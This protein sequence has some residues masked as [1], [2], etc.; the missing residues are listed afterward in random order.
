MEEGGSTHVGRKEGAPQ[1]RRADV[2]CRV[3]NP[4]HRHGGVT[5][6]LSRKEPF[7]GAQGLA[8]LA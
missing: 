2:S 7:L 3:L 6:I 1:V 8:S 4:L 5:L